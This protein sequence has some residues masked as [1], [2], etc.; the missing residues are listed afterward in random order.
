MLA[1][2][3]ALMNY[4]KYALLATFLFCFLQAASSQSSAPKVSMETNRAAKSKIATNISIG[5]S[6]WS[7]N[8][9][10]SIFSGSLLLSAVD[11]VK[12]FSFDAK[13]TYGKNNN[14]LNQREFLTGIQYDYHPL[15]II[16]PF[17]R[18]DLYNNDF[19]NIK[20]RYSGYVGAKYRFFVYKKDGITMSDYSISAALTYVYEDYVPE[21]EIA[22]QQKVRFSIRPKFKQII[23]K[24]IYLQ[25]EI[26]FKPKINCWEDYMIYSISNL[27]FIVNNNIFIKCTY[28]YD[29]ESKPVTSNIKKTD[30]MFIVSLGFKI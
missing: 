12:E 4:F 20:F 11:S 25:S 8:V 10:K 17:L 21:I 1:N 2:L 18:M 5:G 14:K 22:D 3:F 26:Y 27:N 15:S 30:T 16:S 19:K 28:E 9:D 24:N 29:Y 7:G 23:A 13:Y 6:F